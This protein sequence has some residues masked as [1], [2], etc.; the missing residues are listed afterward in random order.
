MLFMLQLL[1]KAGPR[2]IPKFRDGEDEKR[3]H[4]PGPQ[5]LAGKKILNSS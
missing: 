4:F 3:T 5:I 1:A 2:T